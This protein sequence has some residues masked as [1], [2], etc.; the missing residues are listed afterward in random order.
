MIFCEAFVPS[1]RRLFWKPQ[2]FPIADAH[3]AMGFAFLARMYGEGTVLPTRRPL[4]RR[5]S[6][7]SL[8]G[9]RGLLLGISVRL[10][11]ENG[12]DERGH[13]H[14]HHA[15]PMSTRRSPQVYA[16]DE[17][18]KWLR[19]MQSIAEHAFSS[20]RDIET[21]PDAASCGYTPAPDDPAG[22]VNASA[23]R[24]FLLTK[25]GIELSEPRYLETARR[26]LNFVLAS[27]NADGSWYYSTDGAAGFCRSLSHLLCSERH[28]QRSRNSRDGPAAEAPSNAGSAIT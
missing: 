27:Q 8:P 6:G 24:A 15:C 1:A 7:D 11:D 21:G 25:A 28:S 10:G 18:P 12:H 19:I 22:V 13:A 3:Y 5:P 14:D 16:I 4:P 20:Y 23:Y 9:L 2:R 26:N 17:D